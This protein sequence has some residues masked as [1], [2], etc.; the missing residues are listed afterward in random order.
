MARRAFLP[1]L[2]P[3]GALPSLAPKS[4]PPPAPSKSVPPPP[5]SEGRISFA[6]GSDGVSIPLALQLVDRLSTADDLTFLVSWI[7]SALAA[8]PRMDAGLSTRLLR[9]YRELGRFDRARELAAT[10]PQSPSSWSPLDGA[11]LALERAYL[12]I[13]SD[14]L[15]HAQA[16]LR[17]ASRALS[18]AQRGS[19][20]REQF[21]L[22]VATSQLELRLERTAQALAELR[23]A[24]HV[25]ERLDAGAFRVGLS[26]TLGHLSMRLFEPKQSVKHYDA[27]L[28]RSPT[29]SHAALRA[30]GNLAIALA[31]T[32]KTDDARTHGTAACELAR[33]LAPGWRQADACDV[34]AVVELAADRP[35]IA[36][37]TLDEAVTALGEIEQ[38][39][40][41]YE[42]ALRRTQALAML[43]R[44]QAAK[45]WLAKAEQFKADL[46]DSDP[47]DALELLAISGRTME[48]SGDPRDAMVLLLPHVE[49]YPESYV[50]GMVNLVVGRAAFAT[51]DE[52][53][54]RRA[55][56]RVAL[57]GD[58]R[59]WVFPDRAAS[60]GLWELGLKSGDS[61][62]VR[63]AERMMT[64][65]STGFAPPSMPAPSMVPAG[66]S[67]S[68]PPAAS[69]SITPASVSSIPPPPSVPAG[70]AS[71]PIDLDPAAESFGGG[72]TLI[73][74]TTPMGVSR[75]R[76][77]DID[78]ATEGA[79]LV[80]NTIAHAL[81][82]NAREI[83]LER[84]RALEPLVVQ[85]LRR[86]KEGLS[87]E[88]IL[89]AAGGPGPESADAEHRV[90]VLISRVR[91][92][93]GDPTT[94][95]RVRDA[96]EHGRTR[97]R[98]AQSIR[99]AL[100]EPLTTD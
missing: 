84:R 37:Q 57:A 59:G 97:Y 73:Y 95:E 81:R 93:L 11:R 100:V 77:R 91:D 53:T 22:H 79:A 9:A 8:R 40:V 50:S 6:N 52:D 19:G 89:R 29:H 92:L 67:S 58:R 94:I 63:Y 64:Y 4:V 82:V 90:R 87:A 88:E 98:L 39:S 55:V 85:L 75:V 42:L 99:F 56:E 71:S 1:S 78:R 65:V 48:A 60:S 41:R 35:T 36:L 45:Q 33:E 34:L 61:R 38:V 18:S 13:G 62:I 26:M 69:G 7:E 72:E 14:M 74:V 96:G 44:G 24:E 30:H 5:L 17:A 3:P 80:V 51:G 46:R 31:A 76:L 70:L 16:E 47:L 10:L 12:A 68:A 20:L 83:S 49:R 43:G 25:A 86:A 32:G 66:S 27:A 2:P 21:D 15:E 54:A 23:L 28:D